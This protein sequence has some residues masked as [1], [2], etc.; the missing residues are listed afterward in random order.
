MVLWPALA[1]RTDCCCSSLYWGWPAPAS[2][3]QRSSRRLI[4]RELSARLLIGRLSNWFVWAVSVILTRWHATFKSASERHK[5]IFSQCPSFWL[6]L[7]LQFECL[8][9]IQM[10]RSDWCVAVRSIRC[11]VSGIMWYVKQESHF[12]PQ[13]QPAT[14]ALYQATVFTLSPGKIKHETDFY[15]L[16]T[17]SLIYYLKVLNWLCRLCDTERDDFLDPSLLLKKDCAYTSDQVT[18]Y[19]TGQHMWGSRVAGD[20]LRETNSGVRT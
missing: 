4:G 11:L 12:M 5:Q 10:T 17:H 1:L 13:V 14:D 20:I 18:L 8:K 7:S 2:L 19:C 15:P 16:F 9:I 3:G 6:Y